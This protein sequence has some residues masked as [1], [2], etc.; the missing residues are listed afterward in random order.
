MSGRD[1]LWL[2][3]RIYGWNRDG[4]GHVVDG[5]PTYIPLLVLVADDGS[6]GWGLEGWMIIGA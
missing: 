6:I 3:R 5:L 1:T 2:K 4:N